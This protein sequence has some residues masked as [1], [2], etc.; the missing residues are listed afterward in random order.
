MTSKQERV[1]QAIRMLSGTCPCNRPDHTAPTTRGNCIACIAKA[2]IEA[3]E[4][5]NTH[6]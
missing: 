4:K 3:I 1:E 2:A 5:E 6:G